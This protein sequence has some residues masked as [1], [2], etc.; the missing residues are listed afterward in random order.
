VV[1]GEELVGDATGGQLFRSA[2]GGVS[3]AI[4]QIIDMLRCFRG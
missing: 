1:T 2:D 4:H 3:R